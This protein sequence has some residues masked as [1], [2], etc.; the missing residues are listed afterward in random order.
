MSSLPCRKDHGSY[1]AGVYWHSLHNFI[2]RAAMLIS[3]YCSTSHSVLKLGRVL[4]HLR[5]DFCYPLL[6]SRALEV[7]KKKR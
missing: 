5:W 3:N 4:C 6:Y 2:E 7:A 1:M